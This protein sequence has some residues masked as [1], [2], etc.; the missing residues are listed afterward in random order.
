MTARKAALQK[1]PTLSPEKTLI[2][3]K[4]QLEVLKT[5][6][7]RSYHDAESDERQWKYLTQSIIEG[8]FGNPSSNLSKYSMA[9]A[10]GSITSWESLTASVR[11]IST[12]VRRRSRICW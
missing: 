5:I 6:K 12:Y 10:A 4:K 1:H 8:G 9:T 11:G 3:L 2:A 7:G